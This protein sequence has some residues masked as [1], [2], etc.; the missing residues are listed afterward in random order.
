VGALSRAAALASGTQFERPLRAAIRLRTRLEGHGP[1]ATTVHAAAYLRDRARRGAHRTLSERELLATRHSDSA[2]I[3][4]SGRSL[5]EISPTEWERIGSESTI[6]LSEFVRQRF[7]RVDYHVVGEI[8][9]IAE[10]ARLL[11]ESPLYRD[12]ILVLQE[13]WWAEA[14]NTLVGKRL[15]RPGSRV[16]RYRRTSGGSYAPPSRTFRDGLVHGWNTSISCT[17]FALLLGFRR[18][19]LTGID[20]YDR[21]YFWLEPGERRANVPLESSLD[22][23]FPTAEPVI[24]LFGR[25][26]DLLE[27]EGIELLVYNPR[28]LLTRALPVFRF[29]A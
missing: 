11:R 18:I 28:S 27:P 21:E 12:T 13:G 9:D 14:S 26:R 5:L 8:L 25:W 19:V 20:L 7:V 23:P 6:G 15:L 17:N 22:E 16:F 10:Y 3:L 24:D 1:R 2:F 29:D 4:G